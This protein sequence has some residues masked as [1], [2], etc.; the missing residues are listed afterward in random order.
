MVG[1]APAGHVHSVSSLYS[2]V[3][4]DIC[5]RPNLWTIFGDRVARV[6]HVVVL[7]ACELV[8]LKEG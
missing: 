3:A 5:D 7:L 4:Y 8:C 6:V 1:W 2:P